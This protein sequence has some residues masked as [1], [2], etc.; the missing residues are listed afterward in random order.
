MPDF[1]SLFSVLFLPILITVIL[2][3]GLKQ[4]VAIYDAFIEG[5]KEGLK[6]CVDIL[7]FLIGIFIA[8]EALTCSGAMDF[9]ESAVS[10]VFRLFG[11][12]EELISV[13]FLR[14]ISGSGSLVVVEK[15]MELCGPD[16][17]AGRAA[18]VMVGS[19]ETIFYVL[20]LYFSVTA[21]KKM[22]HAF[23]SGIIGYFV[24]ILASIYICRFL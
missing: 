12:P 18:A 7:P 23:L 24:G 10:P 6:T 21:V 15:V 9:I 8:I 1:L 11:I 16:S 5:A 4:K 17:F 20:A 3:Y 14:P 19:C 13:I 2:V 22:R